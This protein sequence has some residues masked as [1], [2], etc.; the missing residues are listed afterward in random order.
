MIT[1]DLRLNEPRYASLPNIM[2]ARKKPLETKAAADYGVD[3]AARL[4][5]LKVAEAGQA[6]GGDQGGDGG[7]PG[8][9][10]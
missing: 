2:K 6:Q 5:V 4:E 1:A 3:V 10:A 9:A 8:G 7:G